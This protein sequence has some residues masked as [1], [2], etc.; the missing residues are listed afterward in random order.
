MQTTRERWVRV[1]KGET[2]AWLGQPYLPEHN[3]VSSMVGRNH[4][5]R[6][7]TAAWFAGGNTPPFSPLLVGE[8]GV[9]KN[10]LIY[11]LA[12]KRNQ[13][14]YIIQG[15][16]DIAAEDLACSVRMSG[17]DGAG[18]EYVLSQLTTAMI[19]GG[20]C[21]ID[22]I[23][24]IRPRALS[25]LGSVL[26][27]RRYI[28]STMLGEVIHAAPSFRFIAAT[29]SGEVNALPSFIRSRMRP[30]IKVGLPEKEELNSI[31]ERQF[32]EIQPRIAQLLDTFWS[33]WETLEGAKKAPSPRDAIHLFSL[34]LRLGNFESG[35]A[36][37]EQ[38]DSQH[39]PD[40]C[41]DRTQWPLSVE[42]VHLEEAFSQ[43]YREEGN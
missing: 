13:E 38:L 37:G 20:I 40:K 6:M 43:L 35:W 4:E 42:P 21:F 17:S 18:M 14:L 32:P 33:L 41:C 9:G 19:R 26:D 16:E 2:H 27:D 5:L 28:D 8:P 36:M 30:V 11:E 31:I 24:K 29:N 39:E 15:H 34:A 23:G 3:K 7:I 10:R 1:G 22:E 25:L 12:A